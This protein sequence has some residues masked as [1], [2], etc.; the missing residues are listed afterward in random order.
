[1]QALEDREYI[2]ELCRERVAANRWLMSLGLAS[3]WVW[4]ASR[5]G[6]QRGAI[7]KQPSSQHHRQERLNPTSLLLHH[8]PIHIKTLQTTLQSLNYH[9]SSPQIS[10]RSNSRDTRSFLATTSIT[11]QA[12]MFV[13][14]DWAG[15]GLTRPACW[16][17]EVSGPCA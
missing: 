5:D 8:H 1:M 2:K 13:W 6:A 12:P 16:P 7:S 15:S 17:G 3:P 11:S 9:S 10:V 14:L 4:A